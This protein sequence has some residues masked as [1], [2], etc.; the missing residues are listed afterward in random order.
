MLH[1]Y[2]FLKEQGFYI[3][4]NPEQWQHH[5][6]ETNYKLISSIGSTSYAAIITEK[7]FVKIAKPIKLDNWKTVTALLM[8]IFQQ[9]KVILSY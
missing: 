8:E 5:F 7:E 1:H 6:D 3:C 4:I 9:Y 2:E